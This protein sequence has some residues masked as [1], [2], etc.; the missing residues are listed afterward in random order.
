MECTFQVSPSIN[1]QPVSVI[2]AITPCNFPFYTVDCFIT[3]IGNGNVVWSNYESI[4]QIGNDNV[5]WTFLKQ[6]SHGLLK[7]DLKIY[8][9]FERILKF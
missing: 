5:L 6:Q 9:P 4:S 2:T 3:A 1:L 8:R 7:P